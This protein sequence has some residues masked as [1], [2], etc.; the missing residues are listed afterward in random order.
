MK[1]RDIDLRNQ[2]VKARQGGMGHGPI[3]RLFGVSLKTIG[4]YCKAFA[5]KGHC[6]PG[7]QGGNLKPRLDPHKDVVLGWI[8]E[9]NDLSLGELSQKCKDVL[10]VVISPSGVDATL[11]RWKI[12]YKKKVVHAT[13]Q[14]RPDVAAGRRELEAD[15]PKM[16]PARIFCVDECGMN[17]KMTPTYGRAPASERCVGDAPESHRM[18]STFVAALSVDGIQAPMLIK[19]GIDGPSFLE[20][21]N[22][23]L[24]PKL[25]PGDVVIMD[26]LSSHKTVAVRSAV[27]KTGAT[28]RFLPPYSPD[29]NPIEKAFSKLKQFVRKQC[30]RTWDVLLEAV[31]DG[32][33]TF[34]P[35]HCK[36][37]FQSC[38]YPTS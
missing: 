24:G 3:S 33:K 31:D 20:Y 34:Q 29:F 1:S 16:D 22:Q 25:R 26:N 9:R 23:C 5:E 7:K 35:E 8:K 32:L 14:T 2:I 30:A 4:R 19:G 21:V 28:I 27:E 37:Y 12:T 17:T 18:T 11:S 36:N 10:G 13:E 15:Q 6:R 38:G